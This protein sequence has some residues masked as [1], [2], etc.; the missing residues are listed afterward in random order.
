MGGNTMS[1][2]KVAIKLRLNQA[3]L[4]ELYALHPGYGE[5][6]RVLRELC[7]SYLH[8]RKATRSEVEAYA[9][10]VLGRIRK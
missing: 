5:A 1:T 10:A 9:N 7:E 3:V 8:A 6:Q 4:T 2:L